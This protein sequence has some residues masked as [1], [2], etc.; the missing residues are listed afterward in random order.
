[1]VAY[2]VGPQ[3]DAAAMRIALHEHLAPYE[4]P[5]RIHFVETL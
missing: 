3:G 1:V 5:K 4:I 2:V